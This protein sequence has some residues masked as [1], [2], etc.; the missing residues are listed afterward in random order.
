MKDPSVAVKMKIF[1][2]II[3]LQY[4]GSNS[5]LR[6]YRDEQVFDLCFVLSLDYTYSMKMWGKSRTPTFALVKSVYFC[7]GFLMIFCVGSDI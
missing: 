7:I 5:L 1:A 4:H 3:G 2:W 6:T